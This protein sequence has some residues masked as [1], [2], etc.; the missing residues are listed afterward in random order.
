MRF[1]KSSI[2]LSA[3]DVHL[4]ISRPAGCHAA[5][6]ERRAL[7]GGTNHPHPPGPRQRANEMKI[8]FAETLACAAPCF[9]NERQSAT[10]PTAGAIFAM[11]LLANLFANTIIRFV[12]QNVLWGTFCA[13]SYT[14]FIQIPTRRENS[15]GWSYTFCFNWNVFFLVFAVLN[16]L[17]LWYRPAA[18][19]LVQPE[20]AASGAGSPCQLTTEQPP[21]PESWTAQMVVS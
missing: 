16:V 17:K 13:H 4:N 19:S 14:N 3:L 12:L 11:Q 6:K 8:N 18:S 2:S 1:E 20:E 9:I 5:T 15:F 21:P 7:T 10:R